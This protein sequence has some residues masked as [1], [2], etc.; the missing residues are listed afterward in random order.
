MPAAVATGR[1]A[2]LCGA[3]EQLISQ[4]WRSP[5]V[6]AFQ[7]HTLTHTQRTLLQVRVV[8]SALWARLYVMRPASRA[9][10]HNGKGRGKAGELY[11]V[12]IGWNMKTIWD[13]EIVNIYDIGHCHAARFCHSS[14]SVSSLGTA[15]RN[16]GPRFSC[17]VVDPTRAKTRLFVVGIPNRSYLTASKTP[18]GWKTPSRQHSRVSH[19]RPVMRRQ[20]QC[21]PGIKA[22]MRATSVMVVVVG[23]TPQPAVARR[24]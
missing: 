8:S 18:P 3:V 4:A 7:P 23:A 22:A 20:V 14:R 12:M 11:G 13:V 24:R 15:Q 2:A 9:D 1:D 19:L 6:S 5:T 10:L 21:L 17:C 16:G